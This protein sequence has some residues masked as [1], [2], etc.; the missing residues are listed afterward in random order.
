[1]QQL[2]TVPTILDGLAELGVNPGDILLVHCAMS[3]FGQGQSAVQGGAQ[4]IIEALMES[5]GGAGTLVM[6]TLSAGR[7]D[8]S[9]WQNPPMPEKYWDRVRFETPLFHPQKTP[10][11]N[12]MSVVYELFRTWPDVI[13]THHPHSSFAAWGKHRNEVTGTHRL[14][15]RFG[16][17]SPLGALYRLNA[18]VLFLGTGYAT[19]T[20]FHLAE[21]RLPRPKTR[22][23]M[24][25]QLIQGEK[26]LVKY[27][28]VNTNS[29]VFESIG[30]DFETYNKQAGTSSIRSTSI[31]QAHSKL[32]ELRT[33]V[34]FAVD[35]LVQRQQREASK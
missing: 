17:S 24:S 28:D 21:Y 19:N 29:R 3:K 9:E 22:A 10:T 14:E 5:V 35:W 26:Q 23:F 20:C 32:F 31:G 8:P 30:D 12:S 25:V 4:A 33:A 13:R 11:D 6:P 27:Y 1:M 15:E 18:R 2:I 34:D 16:N 7:F